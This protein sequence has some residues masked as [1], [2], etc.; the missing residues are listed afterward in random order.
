MCW[1]VLPNRS[2]LSFLQSVRSSLPSSLTSTFTPPVIDAHSTKPWLKWATLSCCISLCNYLIHLVVQLDCKLHEAGI[3]VPTTVSPVPGANCKLS[4]YLLLNMVFAK[5]DKSCL[6]NQQ[7]IWKISQYMKNIHKLE[8]RQK[9]ITW[10]DVK[11]DR[12]GEH[13]RKEWRNHG[14]GTQCLAHCIKSVPFW[15]LNE[16]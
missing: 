4:K 15:R 14:R 9:K 13:K 12:D 16:C 6:K 3:Y 11:E 1:W 8:E 2:L 10:E 5:W 7:D